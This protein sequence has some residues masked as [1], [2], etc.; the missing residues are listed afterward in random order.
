MRYIQFTWGWY[1]N[2][3]R[4]EIAGYKF[5]YFFLAYQPVGFLPFLYTYIFFGYHHPGPNFPGRQLRRLQD[6]VTR[7]GV[8]ESLGF[9][10]G[11]P[12]LVLHLG[13]ISWDVSWGFSWRY[14]YLWKSGGLGFGFLFALGIC[15]V[16]ICRFHI[17]I[18][19]FKRLIKAKFIIGVMDLTRYQLLAEVWIWYTP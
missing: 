15:G 5:L 4:V 11:L 1:F 12:P 13:V 8:E 3:I 2:Q 10:Q 17:Y 7:W 9:L 16:Y 14:I 18:Y 6:F 19:I